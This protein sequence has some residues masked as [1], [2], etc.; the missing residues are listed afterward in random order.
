MCVDAVEADRFDTQTA[1]T[2]R[3]AANAAASLR[4]KDFR[5]DLQGVDEPPQPV[6]ERYLRLPAEHLAGAGDVRLAHLRVVDRQ[7]LEDDLA[8]R[9]RHPQDELGQFDQ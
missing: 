5:S 3:P 2:A 6:L 8:R 1:R 4:A 7:R 9:A